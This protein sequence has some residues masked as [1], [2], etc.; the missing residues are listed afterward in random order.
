MKKTLVIL[1]NYN[2]KSHVDIMYESLKPYEGNT[3]DVHI[4]DNNSDTDKRSEYTTIQLDENIYYGGAFRYAVQIV[5]E[6]EDIYDS[7]IFSVGTLSLIGN[8][9]V[10][11]LRDT[12]FSNENIGIVSPSII[13]HGKTQNAW[14]PM[15]NWGLSTPRKVR[16]VDFQ[17]PMLNISLLKE[18]GEYPDFGIAY[19]YD[20]YTGIMAEKLGYSSYVLDYVYAVHQQKETVKSGNAS[21]TLSDYGKIALNGMYVGFDN[22]GMISELNDMRSWA[23]AYYPTEL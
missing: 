20:V 18:I 13:A 11:A 19:G 9:W 22:I 15:L 6:N 10:N 14:K 8:N 3:Y 17:S 1:C 4:L 5:L 21:I 23:N 16:W 7:L 2:M 12:M